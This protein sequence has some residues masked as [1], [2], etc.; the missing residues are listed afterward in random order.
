MQEEFQRQPCTKQSCARV[1]EP[2]SPGK[3]SALGQAGSGE[4]KRSHGTEDVQRALAVLEET[5][6]LKLLISW[7]DDA[8][9]HGHGPPSELT[10]LRPRLPAGQLL[11]CNNAAQVKTEQQG[12]VQLLCMP[13]MMARACM[14]GKH[15]ELRP[16]LLVHASWVGRYSLTCLHPCLQAFYGHLLE[17]AS[18]DSKDARA[19][20]SELLH[21]LFS[22]MPKGDALLDDMLGAL[23]AGGVG[24]PVWSRMLR[25]PAPPDSAG[26]ELHHAATT[27]PAAPSQQAVPE[28]KVVTGPSVVVP[29]GTRLS[30]AAAAWSAAPAVHGAPAV[31]HHNTSL[32]TIPD[33]GSVNEVRASTLQTANSSLYSNMQHKSRWAWGPWPGSGLG[34]AGL[35]WL[36]GAC[37]AATRRS[38][39]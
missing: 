35:F 1:S 14:L 21:F 22:A 33:T 37:E 8:V 31:M 16:V 23:K 20:C 12:R 3:A 4:Q 13:H 28:F 15:R 9:Q 39:Y 2:G 7:G 5:R 27:P 30:M 6:T 10:A 29:M 17:Q 26:T 34:R 25:V 19:S 38:L 11:F 24:G 18:K 36:L 32:S